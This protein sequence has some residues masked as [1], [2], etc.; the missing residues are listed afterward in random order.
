VLPRICTTAALAAVVVYSLG[1][2]R[3]EAQSLP[4]RQGGTLAQWRCAA[5]HAVAAEAQSPAPNAPRFH[6][7]ATRYDVTGLELRLT[8]LKAGHPPMPP[9]DLQPQEALDIAAYIVSLA[10]H[11]EPGTPHPKG[12]EPR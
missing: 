5:C 7:L 9:R 1:V 3:A 2:F 6:D 8:G 10:P 4:V 12:D 11:S